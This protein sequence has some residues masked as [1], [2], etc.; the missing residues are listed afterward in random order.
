MQLIPTDSKKQTRDYYTFNTYTEI[1]LTAIL[2]ILLVSDFLMVD[3]AYSQDAASTSSPP[4][5]EES[6]SRH[7]NQP[8]IQKIKRV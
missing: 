5:Y 2:I 1:S 8:I 6:S 4:R 7:H 3:P